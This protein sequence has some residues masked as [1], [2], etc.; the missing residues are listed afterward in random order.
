MLEMILAGEI[1]AAAIDS[2]VLETELTNQP[3]LAKRIRIVEVLG[4]SPIPPFIASKQ[5]PGD[6]FAAIQN[7]LLEMHAS[8]AGR[9]LLTKQRI[10]HLQLVDDRFYDRI[11]EMARRAE[12]I[13][14]FPAP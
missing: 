13:A 8:R 14:H 6:L 9:M 2:T 4:P 12:G 1:D 5:L 3:K 7:C 10:S 11:R